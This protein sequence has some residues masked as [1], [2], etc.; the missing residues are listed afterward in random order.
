LRRD[1]PQLISALVC[2]YGR[3]RLVV[4]TVSSI[5]ANTHPN[6][7][8][9]VVDQSKDDRT[10]EAL[11]SFCSDPRLTYLRSTTIGKG[12]ALN[13]GLTATKGSTIAITDDDCTVPPNWLETFGSIF[14]MHPKVAVAF[15]CVEAGEHDRAAGFV[16]DFVRSGERMLTTMHD[17]RHVRGL[18][19]GIAVRRDMIKEIGGF[20]PMLGP[21]SRFHD[22]DDRDIAIRALLARYHV[23]ET[24]KIAV[25][26]FGF[27]SWQQGQQLARRN[28][29]GIGAAYSKFL[30]CGRIQLMYIPAREFIRYALWPPIR[31][32]LHLR[33]P[34]GIVRITA[35]AEGFLDGLRTPVD[36]ATMIFVE[37]RA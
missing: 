7:E 16:P 1:D 15:C 24:S 26:H 37:D 6:F 32:V 29:L 33:Q 28:F 34:R 13:V 10:L 2:T 9:V 30:K 22:C 36:R 19:A 23:Y 27:R 17:T 5:L 4:D 8:L 3:G 12:D 31:D 20:D 18:G 14:A 21:G 35:F 25:K 11:E